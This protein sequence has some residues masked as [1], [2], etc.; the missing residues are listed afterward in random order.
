MEMCKREVST[1]PL[2]NRLASSW[3]QVA[4][5]INRIG[6][7]GVSMGISTNFSRNYDIIFRWKIDECALWV[8]TLVRAYK[9][10][11]HAVLLTPFCHIPLYTC[12]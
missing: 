7:C 10:A 6:F 3:P 4:N 8:Y 5:A 2:A 1:E 11:V 9:L 12:I